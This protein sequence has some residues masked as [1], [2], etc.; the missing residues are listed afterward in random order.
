MNM[1]S[2]GEAEDK[3]QDAL[4]KKSPELRRVSAP[5]FMHKSS[6]PMHY[7]RCG[8]IV[9]KVAGCLKDYRIHCFLKSSRAWFCS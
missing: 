8:T 4:R 6:L 7:E 1:K 9:G 2:L 3:L 5:L